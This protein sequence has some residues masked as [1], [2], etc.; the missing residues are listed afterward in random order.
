MRI[1]NSFVTYLLHMFIITSYIPVVS[2]LFRS[3]A[4]DLPIDEKNY[5][6]LKKL[7]LFLVFLGNLLSTLWVCFHP[8]CVS[9]FAFIVYSMLLLMLVTHF[10]SL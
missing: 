9:L 7:G 2:C 1:F 5:L 8:C 4:Y 6:L 3:V 10:V